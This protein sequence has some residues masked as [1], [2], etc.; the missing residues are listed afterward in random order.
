MAEDR[1]GGEPTEEPTPKRLRDARRKGQVARSRDLTSALAFA[2]AYAALA[3][4]A[5]AMVGQVAGF[6]TRALRASTTAGVAP[7]QLLHEGLL[8]LARAAGPLLGAAFIAAAVG[9]A[10]QVGGLFTLATIS[11]KLERL[12]PAKGLKNLFSRKSLVEVGKSLL[13]AAAVA[14]VAYGALASH[15]RDVVLT[16]RGGAP[17]ALA[18]GAQVGGA[19]LWRTMLVFA[20]VAAVDFL[21]QRRAFLKELRMT[22][23]EVTQEQKQSEGDPHHKAERQRLHREILQHGMLEAVRTADCVIVNPTHLA[24]ALRYDREAMGAPQVVAKG[25]R[26]MAER[27]KEIARQHGV[28]I[29]RDVPLAHALNRVDVGAEIPEELYQAVAEVL[30]FVYRQD[31]AHEKG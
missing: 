19:L 17:A 23:Y 22:R 25:E 30:R 7:A 24:V 18:V 6:M 10:V 27:I 29:M 21:Y 1:P 2:A 4:G 31:H 9:G 28:P 14:A 5:A 11:P 13:K 3:L 8:V 26:L 12:S 20:V 15:A 16:A